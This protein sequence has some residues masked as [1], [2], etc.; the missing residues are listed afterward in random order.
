M[1]LHKIKSLQLGNQLVEDHPYFILELGEKSLDNTRVR[2]RNFS[3]IQTIRML[4][5]LKDKEE[6]YAKLFR[7]TNWGMKKSFINYI[8]FCLNFNLIKK[9]RVGHFMIYNI[10]EKGKIFLDLFKNG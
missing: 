7:K 5:S 1:N 3:I 10:T 4:E 8:H 9:E 2:P 6:S